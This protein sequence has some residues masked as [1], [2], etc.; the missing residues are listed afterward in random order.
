M[1]TLAAGSVPEFSFEILAFMVSG[2]ILGGIAGRFINKKISEAMVERLF[3]GA[4]SVIILI[5]IYNL[6]KFTA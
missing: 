4:M 2:G 3:I 6:W 5:N 1:S